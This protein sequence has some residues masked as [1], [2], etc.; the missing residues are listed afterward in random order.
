[1]KKTKKLAFSGIMT[2]LCVVILF[3]GSLFST[4]D[5]SL[6]AISGMLI[7]L[8]VIELGDKHAWGIFV[9][10]SLI[11]FLL[12]PTKY[13]VFF[14]A[15]FLGWYPI[16]KRHFERLHPVLAWS[17]KISAINVCLALS[18]WVSKS[19][20]VLPEGEFDFGYLLFGLANLTF[21]L[22]DICLSKLILLYLVKLRKILKLNKLL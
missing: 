2:A 7:V 13:T 18:I 22:Y 9:A 11:G 20:F 6:S 8:A 19:L 4:I 17:V 1:M 21:V 10:A 16:A 15:A 12:I 14:F 3:L 5:L